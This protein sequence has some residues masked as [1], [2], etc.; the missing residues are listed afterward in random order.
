MITDVD[1]LT[2]FYDEREELTRLFLEQNDL[3]KFRL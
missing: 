3:K 2:V 1:S